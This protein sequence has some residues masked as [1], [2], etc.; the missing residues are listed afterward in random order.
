[1]E[2]QGTIRRIGKTETFA[3]GFQK[4]RIGIAYRRTISTAYQYRV[5]TG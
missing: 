2:L 1:M 4:K 5:F 3:G